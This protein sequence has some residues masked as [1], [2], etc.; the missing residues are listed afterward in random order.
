MFKF[1]AKVLKKEKGF[2][3][4]ELLATLVIIGVIAA[5]AV[6]AI[7]NVIENSKNDAK[8]ADALMIIDA[9][10]LEKT[11]NPSHNRWTYEGS[12]TSAALKDY[13]DKVED[14]D[15]TVKYDSA[16]KTYTITGHEISS[17]AISE[18]ELAKMATK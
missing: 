13:V 5:I 8:V 9:A 17:K 10:K 6:P 1:I 14:Q 15:W 16:T 2:T 12:A 4:I 11:E 18:D 7:G 3:L